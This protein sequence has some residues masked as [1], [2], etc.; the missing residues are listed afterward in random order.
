MSRIL[1]G[2]AI[3]NEHADKDIWIDKE[4]HRWASI[5]NVPFGPT[6]PD[7]FPVPTIQV[8]RALAALSAIAPE[9]LVEAAA[10]L[11]DRFFVDVEPISNE[12]DFMP[13]LEE[14]LG[15]ELAT[16]V[17]SSIAVEGKDILTR[18]TDQ[19]IVDGAFGLPYFVGEYPD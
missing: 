6:F 14:Q 15:K 7:P 4:R 18:N 3:S 2:S 13:V 17:A 16:R 12:D 9:R 11:Y 5:F 1:A 19:A 8:Q 10:A